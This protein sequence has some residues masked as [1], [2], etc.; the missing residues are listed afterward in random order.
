MGQK[1]KKSCFSSEQPRQLRYIYNDPVGASRLG[2][3]GWKD[4]YGCIG[5]PRCIVQKRLIGH[6][7]GNLVDLGWSGLDQ[8]I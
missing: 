1:N 4:C 8:G 3:L 6:G 5:G 7:R 2:P